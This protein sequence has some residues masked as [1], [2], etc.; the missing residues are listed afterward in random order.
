[1][2][3]QLIPLERLLLDLRGLDKED[4]VQQYPGAFLLAMGYLAAEEIQDA[5]REAMAKRGK[6]AGTV[7]FSFGKHMKHETSDSHTFAGLVFFLRPSPS[8]TDRPSVT[9][10][11]NPDCDITVPDESVS[12]AHCRIEVTQD[13]VCISDEGSTNG[14]FVNLEQLDPNTPSLVADE[15]IISIGRYSFQLLTSP[16]LYSELYVLLAMEEFEDDNGEP[17]P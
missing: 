7:S 17:A 14:T 16:T 9:V 2:E 13:G 5:R 3:V 11:R 12:E 1:M 8:S 4:F 10:G 15:D 6:Q